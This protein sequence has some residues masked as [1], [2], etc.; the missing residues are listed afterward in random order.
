M[1][2]AAGLLQR[3]GQALCLSISDS[4]WSQLPKALCSEEIENLLFL[5]KILRPA[6][7]SSKV[8]HSVHN[9]CTPGTCCS[10]EGRTGRVRQRWAQKL[11]TMRAGQAPEGFRGVDSY[12]SLRL[13]DSNTDMNN[14]DNNN[15]N[16]SHWNDSNHSD[17]TT[18]TT[19]TSTSNIQSNTQLLSSRINLE[20]S[21]SFSGFHLIAP[22]PATWGFPKIRGYHFG[23]P[24]NKD[25]NIL[26]SLLGF[27]YLGELLHRKMAGAVGFRCSRCQG[28]T[29]WHCFFVS[30]FQS[31]VQD[32][33]LNSNQTFRGDV[34]LEPILEPLHVRVPMIRA[35]SCCVSRLAGFRP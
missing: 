17:S 3:E 6:H 9:V 15:T 18:T 21:G 23:G 24:N 14:N 2:R 1:A 7:A 11:C 22:P 4:R 8:P 33:R 19:T 32:S 5:F 20:R 34:I 28:W 31:P 30:P 35:A 16:N 10:A 26:G 12:C 29:Y 13:F 25:Y 27:P